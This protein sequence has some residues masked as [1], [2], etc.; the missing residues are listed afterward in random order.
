MHVQNQLKISLN[1]VFSLIHQI[2]IPMKSRW[3]AVTKTYN[4][5]LI[6]FCKNQ[7]ITINI[8]NPK[9]HHVHIFQ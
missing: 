2:N 3:N 7:S 9:R 5:K 4:I 6:K 8:N 1:F